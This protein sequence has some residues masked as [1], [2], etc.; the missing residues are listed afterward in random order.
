MDPGAEVERLLSALL[1]ESV[2]RRLGRVLLN[3]LR[4]VSALGL[5]T[6]LVLMT[7][8]YLLPEEAVISRRSNVEIERVVRPMD[9]ASHIVART[10]EHGQTVDVTYERLEPNRFLPYVAGCAIFLGVALILRPRSRGRDLRA[11]SRMG[12]MRAVGPLTAGLHHPNVDVHGAV[13][14][15]LTRLLP[16][17]T[18]EEADSLSDAER[19]RL[20]EAL[21]PDRIAEEARF[22][23]AV[24]EWVKRFGDSGA[25]PYVQQFR[26]A[27]ARTPDGHRAVQLAHECVPILEQR[28][29]Q[30]RDR[31]TLLRPA[32]A[33]PS[34]LLLRP[35]HGPGDTSPDQLLRPAPGR[36]SE[37]TD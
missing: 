14:Y 9:E 5:L 29:A 37:G 27:V 19:R 25:L 26:S 4:L 3:V 18:A 12:D 2:A 33:A 6:G 11:L 10:D 32:A 28:I 8:A 1:R 21:Q 15:A 24:I 34:T 16:Q 36:T 13:A 30:E 17:A 20:Y 35:A 7:R 22:Q 31:A 23:L